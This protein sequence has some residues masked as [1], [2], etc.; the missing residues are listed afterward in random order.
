MKALSERRENSTPKLELGTVLCKSCG[1]VI[2]TLPTDGAKKIYG[3][4]A[5]QG[6]ASV[7]SS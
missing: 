1:E 5:A 3:I 6:C 7:N 2:G 4:C